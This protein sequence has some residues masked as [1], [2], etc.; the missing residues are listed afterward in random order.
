MNKAGTR[1]IMFFSQAVSRGTEHIR[2][3]MLAK[4]TLLSSRAKM[5]S[6]KWQLHS[7][8]QHH[9]LLIAIASQFQV[10]LLTLLMRLDIL[11]IR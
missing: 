3:R 7:G 1:A 5:G 6:K 9:K 4:L 10:I 8:I 11:M 2:F